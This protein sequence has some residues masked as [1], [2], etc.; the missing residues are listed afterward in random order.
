MKRAAV[1]LAALSTLA[2]AACAGMG[3]RDRYARLL[4]AKANPTEVIAT[5]LAF[6][7]AAQEDGQWTAFRDYSTGDAVMFVPQAVNAHEWLSEQQDPAQTVTWQP[8][9]VWSSCDGT[10]AVTRGAAQWPNGSAGE[11]LTVW[12]RQ[13]ND[14]YRWVADLGQLREAPLPQPDF[15]RTRVAQCQ[16]QVPADQRIA[17]SEVPSTLTGQS[18]DGTL[19]YRIAQPSGGQVV[20]LALW[21]GEAFVE[22][23]TAV[24]E[25]E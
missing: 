23:F 24:F 2:L 13:S 16:P 8:H 7:R 9:E 20:K 5:E 17:G 4:P 18:V 21:D 6:A 3:A 19:R 15:I 25:S 10:V 1:L 11:F 12:E 22:G 14:T